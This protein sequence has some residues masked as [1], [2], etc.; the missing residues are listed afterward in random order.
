[1]TRRRAINGSWRENGSTDQAVAV[2]AATPRVVADRCRPRLHVTLT[3]TLFSATLPQDVLEAGTV[4]CQ[5]AQVI[6]I[7]GSAYCQH[8]RAARADLA[9]TVGNA[10][11]RNDG[12]LAVAWQGGKINQV[13]TGF[14]PGMRADRV[15]VYGVRIVEYAPGDE[16]GSDTLLREQIL[17]CQRVVQ[18]GMPGRPVSGFSRTDQRLDLRLQRTYSRDN[19]PGQPGNP[20]GRQCRR[21]ATK[22]QTGND[23][24]TLRHRERTAHSA[25]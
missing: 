2:P 21:V 5:I 22:Q 8:P 15:P 11:L 3:Q 18:A 10:L 7:P 20:A 12:D 13:S 17:A 4:P 9:R 1:M 24:L 19:L 6:R 14:Q 16:F 23:P 25:K